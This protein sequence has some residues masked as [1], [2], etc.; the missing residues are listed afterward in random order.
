MERRA[1]ERV[2]KGEKT[3]LFSLMRKS[4]R[5]RLTSGII[6]RALDHGDR[7]AN[8]LV[9]E[10]VRAAGPAIASVV[11]VLD[12]E[13]VVIGGGLGARLGQPFVRRIERSMHPYLLRDR[14]DGLPVLPAALGDRSGAVGAV[15]LAVQARPA[16]RPR[17]GNPSPTSGPRS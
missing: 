15:V 7:V 13:A 6:A 11:N 14:G 2:E 9:N 5:S 1:R 4:G 16:P 12:V 10:A 3:V 17:A 8:E